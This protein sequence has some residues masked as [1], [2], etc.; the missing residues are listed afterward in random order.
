MFFCFN[1]DNSK[2]HVIHEKLFPLINFSSRLDIS[3]KMSQARNFLAQKVPR[4]WQSASMLRNGKF[5]LLC[6]FDIPVQRWNPREWKQSRKRSGCTWNSFNPFFSHRRRWAQLSCH[7]C[8]TAIAMTRKYFELVQLL[9]KIKVAAA[10]ALLISV[11]AF[12]FFVLIHFPLS[13]WHTISARYSFFPPR[14]V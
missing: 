13:L 1:L 11:D 9:Q 4:Q 6:C 14:A 7:N 5:F 12:I 2:A 10:A 8:E 3:S